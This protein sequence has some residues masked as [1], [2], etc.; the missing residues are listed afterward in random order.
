VRKALIERSKEHRA[1]G[2]EFGLAIAT[3]LREE[4]HSVAFNGHLNILNFP[5]FRV[6]LR[7]LWPTL[8]EVGQ[9][10]S[11]RLERISRYVDFDL[12]VRM[13]ELSRPKDF[14]I[15]PPADV[16]VRFPRCLID[17]I[18]IELAR[19]WCQSPQQ[20]LERIKMLNDLGNDTTSE[21]SDSGPRSDVVLAT[22]RGE[23]PRPRAPRA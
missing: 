15:A 11:L 18:S 8:G 10:W 21:G 7:L 5:G 6:R 19:Y 23:H 1:N 17:P 13:E 4:G 12:I 14:F 3:K 20:L 16:V 2:R 22:H 9:V